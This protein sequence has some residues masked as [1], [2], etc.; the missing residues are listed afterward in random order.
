MHV[1]EDDEVDVG[2]GLND[3]EEVA[4][5]LGVVNVALEVRV[6]LLVSVPDPVSECVCDV[7]REDELENEGVEVAES[8]VGVMVRVMVAD[9][10]RLAE[11]V[12]LNDGDKDGDDEDE[13]EWV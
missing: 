2:R 4:V 3:E 8:E 9:S 13:V 12:L 1:D 5:K 10:V 7:V 6:G 11:N